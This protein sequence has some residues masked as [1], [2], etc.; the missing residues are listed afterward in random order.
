M[1][2]GS[3]GTRRVLVQC[4]WYGR[5]KKFLH[6]IIYKY[7]KNKNLCKRHKCLAK[8]IE[9]RTWLVHTTSPSSIRLWYPLN[10]LTLENSVSKKRLDETLLKTKL[11]EL[12]MG[13]LLFE[14]LQNMNTRYEYKNKCLNYYVETIPRTMKK[15]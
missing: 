1:R 9:Y 5:P 3:A 4:E 12:S 11:I 13:K 15:E 2:S 8:V 6:E 10:T 14:I 7:F